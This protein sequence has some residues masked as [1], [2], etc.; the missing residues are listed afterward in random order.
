MLLLPSTGAVADCEAT[1]PIMTPAD[2]R[3]QAEV[4]HASCYRFRLGNKSV[5]IQKMLMRSLH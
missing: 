4:T 5:A 3:Q 1:C 2:D